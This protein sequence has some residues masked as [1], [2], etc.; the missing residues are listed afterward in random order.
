MHVLVKAWSA[1][2]QRSV[3]QY[4][5]LFL[6]TELVQNCP[7]SCLYPSYFALRMASTERLLRVVKAI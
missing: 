4:E 5:T 2:M 7:T 1:L 6:F 3:T